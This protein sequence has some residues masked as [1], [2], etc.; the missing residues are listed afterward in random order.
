MVEPPRYLLI[1]KRP[2]FSNLVTSQD[3]QKFS[4]K[5]SNNHGGESL[6]ATKL[7]KRVAG[8]RQ[9]HSFGWLC[10]VYSDLWNHTVPL[11]S[12]AIGSDVTVD[13]Y[14]GISLHQN[15]SRAFWGSPVDDEYVLHGSPYLP[16][17]INVQHG[18]G[19]NLS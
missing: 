16:P 19:P 10:G 8:L 5:G 13:H 1:W 2:F 4:P 7:K 14:I 9:A 18:S 17:A 12:T 11:Q 6:A 15:T 3:I